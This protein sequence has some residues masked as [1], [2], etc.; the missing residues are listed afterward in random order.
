M[1]RRRPDARSPPHIAG[2]TRGVLPALPE[3]AAQGATVLASPP[4]V[5]APHSPLVFGAPSW[6]IGDL[7]ASGDGMNSSSTFTATDA[8]AYEQMMGRWSRRLAEP[9]LDFAG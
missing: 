7:A 1:R 6:P 9:F 5:P 8:T 4:K 3:L 2:R